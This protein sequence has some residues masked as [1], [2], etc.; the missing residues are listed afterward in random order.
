MP[1]WLGIVLW[2]AAGFGGSVGRI[3]GGRIFTI[4]RNVG[5]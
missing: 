4:H 3:C 1:E 5:V 2:I